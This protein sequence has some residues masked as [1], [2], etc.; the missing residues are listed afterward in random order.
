M[1]PTGVKLLLSSKF[2][3]LSLLKVLGDTISS[4]IPEVTLWNW[5]FD[6]SGFDGLYFFGSVGGINGFMPAANAIITV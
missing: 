2:S 1:V 4:R 3:F 5:N 6:V